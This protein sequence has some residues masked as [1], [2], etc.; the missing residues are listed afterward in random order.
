MY[1]SATRIDPINLVAVITIA[2]DLAAAVI[3][4]LGELLLGWRG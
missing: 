1:G 4:I 2:G 3:R